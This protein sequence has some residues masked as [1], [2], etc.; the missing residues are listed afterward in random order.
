MFV[1]YSVPV[2]CQIAIKDGWQ[3]TDCHSCFNKPQNFFNLSVLLNSSRFCHHNTGSVTVWWTWSVVGSKLELKTAELT[4]H[5]GW[6]LKIFITDNTEVYIKSQI[7]GQE[8]HNKYM[9]Q[10]HAYWLKLHVVLLH[11][12]T[13]QYI[14]H[15]M[16]MFIITMFLNQYDTE[17]MQ[18]HAAGIESIIS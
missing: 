18:W 2:W 3:S 6:L 9:L 17:I 7:G 15:S 12:Y 5:C 8:E 1:G 14:I 4:F 16:I 10:H 13:Q 11:G